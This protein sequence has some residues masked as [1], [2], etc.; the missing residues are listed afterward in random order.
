MMALVNAWFEVVTDQSNLP[1]DAPVNREELRAR[2][3]KMT[4]NELRMFGRAARKICSPEANRGKLPREEAVIELEEA[5]AE[6]KRRLK[7][8]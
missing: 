3:Q 4:N 1:G 7:G 2:L 6:L 8:P 5:R